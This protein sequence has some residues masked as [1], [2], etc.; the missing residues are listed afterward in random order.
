MSESDATARDSRLRWMLAIAIGSAVFSNLVDSASRTVSEIASL[1]LWAVL[2]N[3]V[4]GAVSFG[5][6]MAGI[7]AIRMYP[8]RNFERV[9][10]RTISGLAAGTG[11]GAAGL[12]TLAALADAGD[13]AGSV[14]PAVGVGIAACAGIEWF[15]LRGR[16]ARSGAIALLGLAAL[17]GAALATALGDRALPGFAASSLGGAL[18]GAIYAAVTSIPLRDG[19]GQNGDQSEL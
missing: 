18:F 14:T 5:G 7:A 1:P 15:M 13:P 19:G 9:M 3:I 12:V 11:G 8:W 17:A 6:I 4:L 16:E 10:G 2:L